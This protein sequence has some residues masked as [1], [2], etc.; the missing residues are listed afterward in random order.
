MRRAADMSFSVGKEMCCQA[1][2]KVSRQQFRETQV[3]CQT[4]P[5]LR[6]GNSKAPAISG[7]PLHVEFTR[8]SRPQMSTFSQMNDRP[9]ELSE[10]RGSQPVPSCQSVWW[11]RTRYT[12]GDD[13]LLMCVCVCVSALSDNRTLHSPVFIKAPSTHIIYTAGDRVVLPCTAQGWPTPRYSTV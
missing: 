10:I 13:V 1:P 6:T 4:V 3:S 9:A 12:A 7:C 11:R 8:G 5:Y 2:C